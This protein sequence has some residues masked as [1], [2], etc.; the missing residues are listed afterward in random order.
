I[1]NRSAVSMRAMIPPPASTSIPPAHPLPAAERWRVALLWAGVPLCAFGIFR[2]R[3][4]EQWHSGRFGELLVLSLLAWSLAWPLRK[5][6][7]WSWA[8]A[9][10]LPWCLAL[11]LFAGVVPVAATLVLAIAALALGGLL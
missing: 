9:L 8:T 11:V 2:Y 3:L 1:L 4:W 6:A 10:A 5:F 7:R